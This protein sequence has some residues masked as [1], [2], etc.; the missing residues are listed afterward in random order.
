MDPVPLDKRTWTTF[1]YVAYWISDATNI[2]TWELASSMLAI[3]LSWFVVLSG[4]LRNGLVWLMHTPYHRRQALP[5]IALGNTIMG[6]VMVLNGTI[7][8]RLHI[9]FPILNRSSF[10]FWLSY[11][12]VISRVVLSLFWFGI[13]TFI[14]SES[15]YQVQLVRSSSVS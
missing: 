6:I 11:F 13:Q 1:N 2:A 8:A 10:G 15:V 7:G 12:S 9:A 3:G 4:T 5:A 14:G